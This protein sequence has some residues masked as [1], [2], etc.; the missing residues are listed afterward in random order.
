M[1]KHASSRSSAHRLRRRPCSGLVH[2]HV[3]KI[4]RATMTQAFPPRE[5]P[6]EATPPLHDLSESVHPARSV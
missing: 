2:R 5:L 4:H 3:Q 6:W 1:P